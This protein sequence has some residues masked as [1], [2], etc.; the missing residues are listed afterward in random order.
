MRWQI[1]ANSVKPTWPA[2]PLRAWAW[3]RS[4]SRWPS[5]QGLMHEGPAGAAVG[6]EGGYQIGD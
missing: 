2:P 3:V 1:A 4:W 5:C 6:G